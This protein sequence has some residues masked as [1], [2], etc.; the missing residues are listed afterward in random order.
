MS[1]KRA[2]Y[3]L[4]PTDPVKN[5]KKRGN[6][7]ISYVSTPRTTG[8]GKG[9][10]KGKWGKKA[11]FKPRTGKT[12]IELRYYKSDEISALTQEQ[13]Y[14]LQDHRSSNGNYK[15]IWYGKAPGSSKYNNG[16]V[17]YLTR[18]QVYSILKEHD[19]VKEKDAASK[20]EMVAALKDE[21]K[22]WISAYGTQMVPGS[23]V[24]SAN[25]LKPVT[26]LDVANYAVD[27]NAKDAMVET[28]AKYPT[29][30][31]LQMGTKSGG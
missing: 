9:R 30:K 21:I 15:R 10:E 1:P 17:N 16:R 27:Q 7:H 23:T 25:Q 29:D 24:G 8:K 18:A 20:N 12:G 13:R 26:V 6:A 31:F 19:A 2:V 22:W 11:S 4:L 28:S 5:K 14:E 3:F